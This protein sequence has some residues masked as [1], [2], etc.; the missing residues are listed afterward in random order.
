[1][2]LHVYG[3]M[4]SHGASAF[5][6]WT[7]HYMY[8]HVLSS[9]CSPRGGPHEGQ[10]LGLIG[11]SIQASKSTASGCKGCSRYSG[12]RPLRQ[13]TRP[14][15]RRIAASGSEGLSSIARYATAITENASLST[16]QEACR[17]GKLLV[18][19]VIVAGA[20]DL[21]DEQRGDALVA[22]ALQ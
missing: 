4:T 19:L 7:A 5:L 2:Y 12:G 15:A 11:S 14:C 8:L 22:F 13:L 3:P 6:P 17:R 20:N 9:A 21:T 18:R 16:A 10:L 1:M